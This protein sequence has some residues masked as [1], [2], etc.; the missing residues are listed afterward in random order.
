MST[1]V[2]GLDW[3][4]GKLLPA[5]QVPEELTVYDIRGATTEIKISVT[6]FVGL[7]NRPQP[8]VY[9]FINDDD[10]FWLNTVFNAVP[11][12]TSASNNDTVLD[13]LL[14]S[15]DTCLQGMVIYDP[16]LPDTINI[17]TTIAGQR[18]AL[19]VSPA[20][21]QQ[22]QTSHQYKVLEDLRT[23]HWKSRIQAYDWARQHL[24]GESSSRLVAG[25]DPTNAS[26]LRSFLTATRTFVYWLDA[27]DII[28]DFTDGLHN[29]RGLM[30]QILGSFPQGAVHL[31]WFKNES[32][33]VSLTSQAG[34]PVLASDHY[35]NLEV[36]TSM[37]QIPIPIPKPP[38]IPQIDSSKVYV[39]FTI[40]DGDNIQFSQHHMR[41]LWNDPARGSIPIGW[42]ISPVLGQDL[43]ALAAYY[44][45]SASANDELVAGP[46]GAGYMFPSRWP[47]ERLPAFLQQTGQL[48]Q[49]MGI[50]TLEL[51]DADFFQRTGIPLVVYI[52]G[53]AMSLTSTRLQEQFASALQPYG[54]TGILHGAG[55]R[56]ARWS[57]SSEGLPIYRNL[58]LARNVR[59]TLSLIKRATAA[60]AERPL[61]L[62]VYI[63]AWTMNPSM[64]KQVVQQL[65]NAYEFVTPGVLLTMLAQTHRKVE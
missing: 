61:F 33:G 65:G 34:I 56:T 31:G 43:P 9:L 29:E 21:A 46:S 50:T 18:D 19:V 63:L 47:T 6:T 44:M 40:S 30:K 11:H 1:E 25:L 27:R 41:R 22:L 13:A 55:K 64:L 42:T 52:G 26:G 48:M 7:I 62:N 57:F 59:H 45:N 3:S 2:A 23:Y 60:H 36:W 49:Q 37:Q 16:A 8:R 15:Y 10:V 28:P 4:P 20:Q 54:L 51:L 35:F 5:F 32:S 58:G 53:T 24:L 39:S 17:A 14:D 38:A 12:T